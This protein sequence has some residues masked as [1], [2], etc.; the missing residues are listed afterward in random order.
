MNCNGLFVKNNNNNNKKY[1]TIHNLVPRA[2]PLKNGWGPTHLREKPWGRGWTIQSS[3]IK[4]Y[5]PG[6][7]HAIPYPCYNRD[8]NFPVQAG[9]QQQQQ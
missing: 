1:R 3:F 4:M 5:G 9:Q 2:F 8:T 6:Q 7:G